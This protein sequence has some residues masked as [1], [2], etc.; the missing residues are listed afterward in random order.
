MTLMDWVFI[1]LL[2]FDVISDSTFMCKIKEFFG[3][4]TCCFKS[5]E[6]ILAKINQNKIKIYQ[7][8][9][10][11]TLFL[12]RLP[13]KL[14]VY[15]SYIER[16][17]LRSVKLIVNKMAMV[18]QSSIILH[19][20]KSIFCQVFPHKRYHVYVASL[21]RQKFTHEIGISLWNLS[22]CGSLGLCD[23]CL[24]LEEGAVRGF[25]L[26]AIIREQSIN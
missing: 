12:H 19:H 11:F 17:V 13:F 8:F 21:F 24:S 26:C 3:S 1:Q 14:L 4:L 7:L 5:L 22:G 23:V 9:H 16:R 2:F 25:F 10:H 6:W 20:E 18:A 15:E